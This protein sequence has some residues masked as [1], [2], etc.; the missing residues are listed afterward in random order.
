MTDGDIYELA[1]AYAVEAHRGQRRKNGSPYID[2]PI[3]VAELVRLSGGDRRVQ[4]AA[5]LHD[6][7]EDTDFDP[8]KIRDLGQDIYDIVDAVTRKGD[9]REEVYLDRILENP[10][11]AMVKNC[12]RIHNLWEC[13]HMT[14]A[15]TR[16]QMKYNGFAS[17]YIEK[18]KAFFLGRFTV[19]LDKSIKKAEEEIFTKNVC[20]DLWFE[21]EDLKRILDGKYELELPDEDLESLTF[22]HIDC[23]DCLICV[24]NY[25]ASFTG[26]R[27]WE[28]TVSSG[29]IEYKG[30]SGERYG[31]FWEYTTALPYW[32]AMEVIKEKKQKAK[33]KQKK[34]NK[35]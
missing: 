35:Q 32:Q 23:V 9:V 26:S 33:N 22:F 17:R 11:A 16:R 15:G 14:P 18:S 13:T 27:T 3:K 19:A 34:E 6:V 20:G 4:A 8:E 1:M 31:G 28:Y 25:N 10:A 7:L 2:H 12:D 21:E 24:K 5:L 29:W 30:D